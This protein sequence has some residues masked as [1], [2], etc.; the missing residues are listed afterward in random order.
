MRALGALRGKMERGRDRR[1]KK[2]GERYLKKSNAYEI[3]ELWLVHNLSTKDALILAR[4]R[5]RKLEELGGW[6]SYVG[7]GRRCRVR[8]LRSGLARAHP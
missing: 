3:T 8:L 6:T 1:R 5:G 2:I 7:G 4:A